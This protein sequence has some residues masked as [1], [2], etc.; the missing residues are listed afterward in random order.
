MSG[1]RLFLHKSWFV[2]IIAGSS[3]G[4]SNF[5]PQQCYTWR[6]NNKC[7]LISLTRFARWCVVSDQIYTVRVFSTCFLLDI[8]SG[9][10]DDN[11]AEVSADTK[12]N[13]WQFLCLIYETKL[14]SFNEKSFRNWSLLTYLQT[15]FV[16]KILWGSNVGILHFASLTLLY[17]TFISRTSL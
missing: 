13:S 11:G 16:S 8:I 6:K 12:L 2:S 10:S 5:L 1:T 7:K 17:P 3:I 9:L 15:V 4:E 14:S